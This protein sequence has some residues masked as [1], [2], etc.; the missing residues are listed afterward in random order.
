MSSGISSTSV[1]PLPYRNERERISTPTKISGNGN[2]F[3]PDAL[4]IPA[5]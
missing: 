2:P 5:S 1:E 3:I 4:P